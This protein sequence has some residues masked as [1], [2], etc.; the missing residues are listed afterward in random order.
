MAEERIE[1]FDE[2]NWM[3]SDEEGDVD[4]SDSEFEDREGKVVDISVCEEVKQKLKEH[5][6]ENS[7]HE[8]EH[9]NG[10]NLMIVIQNKDFHESRQ[11]HGSTA[12]V[13]NLKKTFKRLGFIVKTFKNLSG[14]KM[15]VKL[16]KA[17]QKFNHKDASCFA[18][19]I[20][21]HGNQY[22]TGDYER[23]DSVLGVDEQAISIEYVMKIFNN[24]NCPDLM[25]KPR[26]FFIQACRGKGYD[27]G[28][29]TLVPVEDSSNSNVEQISS[30]LEETYIEATSG[31]YSPPVTTFTYPTPCYSDSM[32]MFASPPGYAAYARKGGSIFVSCLCD[33]FQ[34]YNRK[35]NFFQILS[36][37]ANQMALDF[38]TSNVVED[39]DYEKCKIVPC[40]HSCLTRDVKF[41]ILDD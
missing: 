38:E 8:Y 25:G 34:I 39:T 13:E 23:K 7:H 10:K 14:E 41:Q 21:S 29:E 33:E 31:D 16:R 35:H 32:V 28:A 17:R 4:S 3:V 20:L 9:Y 1:S 2:T 37:V 6:S 36:R 15:D 26:L 24:D 40:I 30:E 18:C 27:K 5:Y 11:R 19:V 12:D 22:E